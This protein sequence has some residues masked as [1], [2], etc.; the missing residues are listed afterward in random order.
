MIRRESQME[1]PVI[2]VEVLGRDG[3][4]LRRFYAEAFGWQFDPP[5]AHALGAMDYRIVFPRN[6]EVGVPVGVGGNRPDDV[7]ADAIFYVCVNDLEGTIDRVQRLGGSVVRG[8]AR[9]PTGGV[10][11]AVVRD[12]EQHL[13]GLVDRT[14]LP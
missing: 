12:P 2:H 11:V 4:A 1:N 9:A 6:G 13:F 3:D 7:Q 5:S 10:R 14:T 8:P